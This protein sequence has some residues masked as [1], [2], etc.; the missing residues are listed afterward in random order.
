MRKLGTVIF[1][2]MLINNK[3][4]ESGGITQNWL[5]ERTIIGQHTQQFRDLLHASGGQLCR[6]TEVKL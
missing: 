4:N 6:E 3:Q 2:Y 5:I 1:V